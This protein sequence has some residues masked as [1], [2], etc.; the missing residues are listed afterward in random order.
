M[1]VLVSM[2]NRKGNLVIVGLEDNISE[3][4]TGQF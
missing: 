4:V 1:I 3:R 2:F